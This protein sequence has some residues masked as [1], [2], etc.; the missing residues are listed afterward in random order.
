MKRTTALSLLIPCVL[1]AGALACAS[2]GAGVAITCTPPSVST[3][4]W[5]VVD[6]G[7]FSIRM[8]ADFVAI[9]VQGIDSRVGAYRAPGDAAEVTFDLGWYSNELPPD[10]GTYAQYDACTDVVGGHPVRIV[11][12]ELREPS[13]IGGRHVVAAAWRDIRSSDPAVHLTVW[14]TARDAAY[15][16]TL[17]AIVR[18]VE[19]KRATG[20]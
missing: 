5:R 6:H 10:Q 3:D 20:D 7:D 1:A 11:V 17:L 18:S 14:T 4:G 12:G 2:G 13:E 9:D 8:P 19:L 15:V 16:P